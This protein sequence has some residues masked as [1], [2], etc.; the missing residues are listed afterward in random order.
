[1]NERVYTIGFILLAIVVTGATIFVGIALWPFKD[2][3]GQVLMISFFVA[4]GFGY[5]ELYSFI[6]HRHHM[7][8]IER[9]RAALH[10]KVIEAAGIAAYVNDNDDLYHLS[11]YAENAKTFPVQIEETTK[12][13]IDLV[14]ELASKG[15][16]ERQIAGRMNIPRNQVR[17]LLGK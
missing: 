14:K 10:A 3:I 15:N 4:T 12:E 13:D 5:F 9:D 8:K 17:K 2:T 6:K 16:S 1:M 7:R 11:A